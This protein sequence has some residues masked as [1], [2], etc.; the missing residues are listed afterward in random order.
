MTG[1]KQRGFALLMHVSLEE[2]APQDHLYRHREKSGNR[3]RLGAQGE[4]RA[5]RFGILAHEV[6]SLP[7]GTSKE[8][9]MPEP[10]DYINTQYLKVLADLL[11]Q[12]KQRTYTL[13]HLEP[14]QTVLDVGCGPGTDTIPLAQ[15]VG[16][17]GQV[18]G[19][20]HD[21]AMIA[22]AERRAEQA[23]CS[24]WCRHLQADATALPLQTS[25]CDACRS[26]RLFQHVPDPA[27][28]LSEMARVTRPGGWIVVFDAD[29]STLS[30]DT[31][32][33]EL[34]QRLLRYRLEH[35]VQSGY[36]G[37]QLYGLFRRQQFT[38]IAVELHPL[39]LTD[40][41][42]CR[43]ACHLEVLEASALAAQV[44][45]EQELQRWRQSLERA[46]AEGAFYSH[47]MGVLV[48][49]R[50]PAGATS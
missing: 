25:R 22:E 18:V 27:A 42:S 35:L 33:V 3:A 38:D 34:E 13:M 20:D 5:S 6:L 19:V 49:G 21:A 29:W 12:D 39:S 32:E 10:R 24:A 7:V 9:G 47:V 30:I 37:R 45:T 44:I 1:S 23:G 26:E 41:A 50:R 4:N 36:V 28:V 16:K 48:A 8:E 31:P 17:S 2:L 14:G 46:Q 43:Y 40:Y 15:I 11:K